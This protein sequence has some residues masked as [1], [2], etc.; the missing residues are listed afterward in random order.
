MCIRDSRLAISQ[1]QVKDQRVPCK[2]GESILIHLIMKHQSDRIS[3]DMFPAFPSSKLPLRSV[4]E[5]RMHYHL[6]EQLKHHSR[7]TKVR[8]KNI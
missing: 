2:P 1:D 4:Y 8:A 6:G 3:A 5:A 7:H